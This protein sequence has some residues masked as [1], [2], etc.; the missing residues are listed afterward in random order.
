MRHKRAQ[1]VAA[2][3]FVLMAGCAP[4]QSSLD[5]PPTSADEA[6]IAWPTSPFVYV[7]GT[8]QDGGL[9]HA[10]CS[11]DRC[12]SARQRPD[13]RRHVASIALVLP[14]ANQVF[15]FDA[16]PDLNHQIY[17]LRE[18]RTGP[19]KRVDRSPVDGIFLT[20]AHIGHYLGLAFLGFEVMNT[21]Q[22]RVMATPKMAQF[23]R[24]N[25]PWS[26]LVELENIRIDE[27][28]PGESVHLPD[29]VV[30]TAFS[31]P[32]RDEYADTLGFVIE[33]PERSLLYLP[34]TDSWS[35][36]QTPVAEFLG[37]VDIALIDGSFYSTD[38]LP[39]RSIESIGH[40]L[41]PTSMDLFQ[42]L[43]DRSQTEIFFTHLNHSN[44]ALDQDSTARD[45]IR[46][47]G[48]EV[49]EEG[50]RFSL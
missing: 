8:V 35:A 49:L 18:F 1:T 2:A 21:H 14:T 27:V 6:I 30:V 13:Q 34:D 9:P 28:D 22:L 4:D 39:G 42:D 3:V 46:Q 44:D 41:I 37:Q 36:W 19:R 20:H 17:Q 43:V 7:L 10:G 47:R 45:E 25:G 29:S 5:L 26:Q 12:E 11:G 48:F 38:E 40:P 16:T 33:G 24:N 50:Q 23:L 15:L 31:A 32:H